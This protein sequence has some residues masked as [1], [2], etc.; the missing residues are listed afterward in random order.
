MKK[1]KLLYLF[2]LAFLFRLV[3]S[4][5]VW[6]PD[7]RNHMDWGIRFF[8]YGP[9]GF[10]SPNANVWNFTWPNQPPGT[11]YIYAATRKLF[12][13]VF[14]IFWSIN[15]HIPPFPSIVMFFL[16][17]NLYPAM[18]KLP[19]IFADLGIA[20]LIYKVI[21]NKKLAKI[22][23]TIFLFNP[24][25]WYNSAVWGQTDAL[26]NFFAFWSFYLLTRKKLTLA[27]LIMAISIYIKISLLIFIPVFVILIIK[28][29]HPFKNIL[30][31]V[32]LSAIFI[33]I[34]TLPFSHSEPFSWLYWL[35]TKK[36]LTN[37]LQVITANAFNIWAAL[38]GIHEQPHTK[39]FILFS[40]QIWG[41]LFFSLAFI[42]ALY[43]F[44][45]KKSEDLIWWVLAITA[46]S[47]FMFLTNMHERYLF[48]LFPYLTII[49]IK[50][51]KLL[52]IYA[53]ISI[54]G[55][56]NLYNFW[57]TPKIEI[58]IQFLSFGDRLMP[59]ILGVL[60][61]ICYLKLLKSY[62]VS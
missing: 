11:I 3:L 44:W 24:V 1:T 27:I 18:L 54:I 55:L 46:F 19:S 16:E 50:N 25:I 62:Q 13:F 14:S 49:A 38:T 2:L 58:I 47:S 21:S 23:A 12:E 30:Y 20:Y 56:L 8:Q 28:Q 9:S 32:L 33:G 48:P 60:S 57:W 37:Q 6:H 36:V 40:Y 7:V 59:R 51:K 45:K 61:F 39:I 4:F 5:I 42:P 31:S 43:L 29:N 22:A 10:F 15:T 53:L 35:Y 17:D 34:I 26:V 52:P 41:Y